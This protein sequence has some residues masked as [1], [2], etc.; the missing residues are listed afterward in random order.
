[1][2]DR[3]NLKKKNEKE[4]SETEQVWKGHIFNKDN[5]DQNKLDDDNFE[6]ENMTTLKRELKK[7]NSEN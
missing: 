3:I 1:M 5:S 6:Q 4:T 2:L 7:D